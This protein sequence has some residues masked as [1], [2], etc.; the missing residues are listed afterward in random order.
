MAADVFI[1]LFGYI[2]GQHP[3]IRLVLEG[4]GIADS[5][6]VVVRA[7]G[8]EQVQ[9]GVEHGEVGLIGAVE[10]DCLDGQ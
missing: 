10:P 1:K 9:A 6:I 5:W 2:M 4:N 3:V 8:T 7:K